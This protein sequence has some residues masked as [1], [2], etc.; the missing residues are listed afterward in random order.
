MQTNSLTK[1]TFE[2]IRHSLIH[3]LEHT[4]QN[5]AETGPLLKQLA[6]NY[7]GD[8]NWMSKRLE[9]FQDLTY[10][11]F[12]ELADQILGKQNRKRVC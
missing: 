11:E 12:L 3:S 2:S 5:L 10:E 4:P 9:G 6:F 1:E 7:D 8:F